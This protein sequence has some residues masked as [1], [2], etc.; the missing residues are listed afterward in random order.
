[1]NKSINIFKFPVLFNL[2]KQFPSLPWFCS[3]CCCALT[4]ATCPSGPHQRTVQISK[5]LQRTKSTEDETRQHDGRAAQFANHLS[6]F[7]LFIH[8]FFKHGMELQRRLKPQLWIQRC[9]LKNTKIKCLKLNCYL[10][11]SLN[12]SLK[13]RTT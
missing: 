5:P 1:M 3:A 12:V 9:L 13:T 8:S 4:L 11:P 2:L 10:K 6:I 7:Y